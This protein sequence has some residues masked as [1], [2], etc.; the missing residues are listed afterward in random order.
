VA[1]GAENASAVGVVQQCEFPH[2]LVLV[3]RD[4]FAEDAERGIAVA[5]PEGAEDLE[6]AYH[7]GEIYVFPRNISSIERM[8]FVVGHHE[9]RHHGIRSRLGTGDE[10]GAA[11]HAM[12]AGNQALRKAAQA[13]ID[14]GLANTRA[15]A[16]EEALADMPVEQISKLKGLQRLIAAARQW[17]R[18]VAGR[19]R[20]LGLRLLVIDT[21]RKFIGSGMGKE[22]AEAAGGRYVQLP[23]ASDQAIAAIALEAINGF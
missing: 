15:L 2:Q 19:S 4:A 9:I 12:W 10:L 21:E 16:V 23:K 5:E 3:G 13:K 1:V 20:S 11:M 17:L 6:A 14:A 18:Q 7:V 22:L 8:Q